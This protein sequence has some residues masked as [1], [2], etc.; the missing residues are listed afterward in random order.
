MGLVA[1]RLAELDA[2]PR[3]AGLLFPRRGRANLA[4]MFEDDPVDRL[5]FELAQRTQLLNGDRLGFDL[6]GIRQREHPQRRL[7][8]AQEKRQGLGA[9]VSGRDLPDPEDLVAEGRVGITG[10]GQHGGHSQ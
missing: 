9:Q 6:A 1:R 7:R 5:V 4:P 2:E 8:F 10:R 3:N